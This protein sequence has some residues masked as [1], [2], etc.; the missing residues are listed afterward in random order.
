MGGSGLFWIILFR[1]GGLRII[2]NI[3]HCSSMSFLIIAGLCSRQSN[4]ISKI[5]L[6]FIESEQSDRI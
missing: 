6:H 1:S 5:Y 3:G 4:T 2:R